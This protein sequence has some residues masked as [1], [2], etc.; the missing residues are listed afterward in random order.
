MSKKPKN[1]RY[2]K[3]K[4]CDICCEC[5]CRNAVYICM[6]NDDFIIDAPDCFICDDFK[7][8]EDINDSE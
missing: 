5:V 8:V 4:N 1:F 6:K 3:N 2:V 7:N